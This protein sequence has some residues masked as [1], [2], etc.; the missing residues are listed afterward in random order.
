MS[1]CVSIPVCIA[2]R[3]YVSLTLAL[4]FF[5]LSSLTTSFYFSLRPSLHSV[6]F[7]L[8]ILFSVSLSSSEPLCI[9]LFLNLSA[10]ALPLPLKYLYHFTSF[11]VSLFDFCLSA[12]T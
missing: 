1:L 5:L 4:L 3:P 11:Q 12:S 8:G 2:R 9:L 7:L 10:S 6:M